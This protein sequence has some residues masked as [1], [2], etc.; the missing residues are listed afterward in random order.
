MPK[1]VRFSCRQN[2][3][4]R[5]LKDLYRLNQS[6]CDLIRYLSDLGLPPDGICD[7]SLKQ[8]IEEKIKRRK[9]EIEA[10]GAYL[11]GS[12][13]QLKLRSEWSEAVR[14]VGV[15]PNGKTSYR[16]GFSRNGKEEMVDFSEI[17]S[18]RLL[19]VLC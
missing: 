5:T 7:L 8:E 19:A 10:K 9:T 17:V 1:K 2:E 16:L 18:M 4:N 12:Y 6:L 14:V 11:A 15:F 3:I 13:Y